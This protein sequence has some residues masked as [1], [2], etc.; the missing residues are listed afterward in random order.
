MLLVLF[1]I[2]PLLIVVMLPVVITE[3]VVVE[4]PEI[5]LPIILAVPAILAPVAVTVN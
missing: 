4:F 1:C 3:V 5:K 2:S